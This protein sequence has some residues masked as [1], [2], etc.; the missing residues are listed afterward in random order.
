VAFGSLTPALAG[1]GFAQ[2]V[3]SAADGHAAVVD[4]FTPEGPLA[5]T[6]GQMRQLSWAQWHVEVVGIWGIGA[7]LSSF[8]GRRW[9]RGR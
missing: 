9:R 2:Y 4:G 5:A 3:I 8:C 7:S 1:T 6:W